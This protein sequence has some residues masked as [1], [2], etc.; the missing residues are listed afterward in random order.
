MEDE[1]RLSTLVRRGL[2]EE[3]HAVDVADTGEEALEWLHVAS[4]DVMIL[5]VM[6]PG[7]DGIEVCRRI[8]GRKNPIPIL[9][10]TAKDTV[11]DRVY[12]LD[13]GADDYL[14]K[15]F[16]FAELSAR[17]R[18]LNR[19]PRE[20]VEPVLEAGDLRIDPARMQVWKRGEEITIANKEFRILEYLM[21]NPN[22]VLTRAMIAEHVWDYDFPNL[23]NV[24]DVHI[25]SLRM[26]LDDPYPG[27]LIQTV[28]GMGYRLHAPAVMTTST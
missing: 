9:L 21:R 11:M 5:D 12:G 18:A 23:T 15:P 13:S 20:A 16:A 17:L 19:R 22:R 2:T 10:L 3:G 28:R 1:L 14:T 27:A 7:I 24:I 4:Y 8:R 25:R 6:L 26:K